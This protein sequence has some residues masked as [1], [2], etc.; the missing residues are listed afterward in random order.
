MTNIIQS[1]INNI[2]S[3]VA[4]AP[5]NI[6]E[7]A[8]QNVINDVAQTNLGRVLSMAGILPGGNAASGS[9]AFG[10]WDTGGAADWRV[11]LSL[12]TSAEYQD[13]NLLNP[14]KETGGFVFPYTPTVY[15]QHSAAYNTVHPTHSNYP[16]PVYTNS[17]VDQFTI[18]GE[19]TVE[20]SREA[21]YWIGAVHYLKS[22]TKMAYGESPNNGAPPPVVKLNGYGDYVFNDVPVVITNFTVN[23]E[24]DVDYIQAP[25]GPDGSWAPARS[26]ITV[27]LMP[28]YSR[29]K[30]NKFSL[31][32]FVNGKYITDI[33]GGYL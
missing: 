1:A 22:V 16:F 9:F 20:N 3:E 19:F 11:K 10:A 25:I 28:A 8:T 7:R 15:I 31:E 14:L 33:N 27:T 24:Q 4:S 17:S 6:V 32:A 30:V 21:E 29:D 23:L 13:S 12:P 5:T 2:G 18:S 26:T